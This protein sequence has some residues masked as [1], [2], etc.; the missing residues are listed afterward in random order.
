MYGLK[1]IC[2]GDDWKNN[3]LTYNFDVSLRGMETWANVSFDNLNDA[4]K[5]YAKLSY[6]E[7]YSL[8]TVNM[9][10]WYYLIEE[11]D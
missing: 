8:Y 4:Y 6:N 10:G 7:H 3:L 1:C 5:Y 9:L 11:K 2:I